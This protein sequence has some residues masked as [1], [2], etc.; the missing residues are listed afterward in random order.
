VPFAPDPGRR[1]L[2]IAKAT[3][4]AAALTLLTLA[5]GGSA[6]TAT[7]KVDTTKMKIAVDSTYHQAAQVGTPSNFNITIKDVGTSDIP[8]LNVLFDE[9]DRFLDKYTVQSAGPCKVDK[10]LPGLSCG[11]LAKG[12]ALTFTMTAKPSTA[13]SYVFKFHIANVKT[14]LN[15]AND[16]EYVYSWTQTIS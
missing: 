9:G 13:G 6:G 7:T 12:A 14:P 3:F 4:A 11:K 10:G 8:N 1:T 2:N 16:I 5:C 15:E